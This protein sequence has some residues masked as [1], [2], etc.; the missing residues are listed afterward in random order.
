[1]IRFSRIIATALLILALVPLAPSADL[2]QDR[3]LIGAYDPAHVNGLVF[4]TNDQNFFGLR[5][6]VYRPGVTIEESPRSFELGPHAANGSYAGIS[7]RPQFDSKNPVTLR[8]SRLDKNILVGRL[9]GPSNVRVAMEVYRPWSEANGS[10]SWATFWAQPDR[11][12]ILGEQVQSP[13]GPTSLRRFFLRT[14]RPATGAASYEDAAGMRKMLA[15]DGQLQQT[16]QLERPGLYHYAALSFDLSQEPSFNF[17]VM[18]GDNF[19]EMER[20]ADK[21]SSK[22]IVAA[23]DQA[24]KNYESSRVSSGGKIGESLEAINRILD[25]N[26]FYYPEKQLE[27]F[28]LQRLPGQQPGPEPNQPPRGAILS[29]NTFL[30]AA[31]SVMIDSGSAASTIRALLE[32]QMPDGRMPLRHHLQYQPRSEP[33]TLAGRSMP[34]IG[35]LCV[36]KVYLATNDLGLLAMAFPRLMQWNDWWLTDRG[37]GQSWRDGNRDGLLEWGFDAELEQGALGARMIQNAAK[38]KLAFSES[39]LEDRPQWSNGEEIRTDPAGPSQQQNDEVR[40]NDKTHTLEFS[41]I[42]L[43]SLYALDTEILMMM[44]REL[45]LTAEA[46]KLQV[47]YEQIRNLINNELWSEQD[48]LY[49]NRH[50]DGRFSRRLSLENFYPLIAGVADE[51]RAKRIVKT[52]QDPK[53][54][55]GERPPTFIPR[56]DPAFTAQDRARGTIWSLSNYLIYVGLKRYSFHNEAAELAQQSTGLARASWEKG[57]KFYDFYSTLDGHAIEETDDTQRTS[58]AGLMFWPGIEELISADPWSGMSIGSLAVTEESRIERTQYQGVNF[59]IILGP[60][61]T[62]VRRGGTVELECEAPVRLRSY[63]GT[64]RA[65]GFAIETKERVRVLVPAVEGKKITVSV[66]DKILGSTS[67]GASASF[68]V[69]EG[70]HK[71]FVVK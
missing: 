62:V 25:W 22:S 2:V 55:R 23:L 16:A 37:D 57:G 70:Q 53:K 31:M 12:T 28:A 41:P 46:G 67:P 59:D 52:L 30:T 13:K 39:G 71:V 42:G 11:R 9:S 21:F 27:Y 49:L 26:R 43:N 1:M 5:F 6:L 15:R 61:R 14:D 54:F 38:L 51:E 3:T 24:E 66:D 36:W 45:G 50:W 65:L 56:D 8:W 44:A 68:K 20:D 35:A 64:D 19:D 58:F 33:S 60:K 69:P 48:G 47:R 34:P 17:V 40:Y 32:G 7:W 4:I 63:R 10:E 18:I 29:W